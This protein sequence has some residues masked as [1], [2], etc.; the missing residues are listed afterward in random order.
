MTVI[1]G[2]NRRQSLV[3]QRHWRIDDGQGLPL[4]PVHRSPHPPATQPAPSPPTCPLAPSPF[5]GPNSRIPPTY[6]I[7]PSFTTC[8]QPHAPSFVPLLTPSCSQRPLSSNTPHRVRPMPTCSPPPDPTRL[9]PRPPGC[10]GGVGWG[11]ARTWEEGLGGE[12][13]QPQ[14]PTGQHGVHTAVP[15]Q[16]THAEDHHHTVPPISVSCAHC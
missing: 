14:G 1:G 2:G 16:H 3:N 11:G 9:T 4:F 6:P 15:K 7:A 13:R 12:Q 10:V 8:R 5:P